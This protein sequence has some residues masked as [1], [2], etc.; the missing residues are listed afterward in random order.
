MV[1][2]PTTDSFLSP[3]V[4]HNI[5][6]RWLSSAV[7]FG[8]LACGC[9]G[10]AAEGE[11]IPSGVRAVAVSLRYPERHLSLTRTLRTPATVVGL[12]ALIDRLKPPVRNGAARSQCGAERFAPASLSLVFRGAGGTEA[13]AK[14]DVTEC[15]NA[16]VW[17][18]GQKQ[19]ELSGELSLI[20]R[21]ISIVLDGPAR[22]H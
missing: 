5:T 7:V 9:G 10:T 1:V 4:T 14:V 8:L 18:R 3:T 19:P 21:I 11:R 2:S 12:V 15:T 6:R 13:L 20:N 16:S 17:V 22:R